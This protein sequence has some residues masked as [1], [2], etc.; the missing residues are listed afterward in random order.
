MRTRKNVLE[1]E[2]RRFNADHVAHLLAYK[3]MVANSIYLR[4]VNVDCVYDFLRT[5]KY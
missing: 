2:G 4:H 1:S 3:N 5:G